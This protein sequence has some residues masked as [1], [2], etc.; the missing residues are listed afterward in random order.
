MIA[1]FLRD[2]QQFQSQ[3]PFFTYLSEFLETAILKEKVFEYRQFP[4]LMGVINK[5]AESNLQIGVYFATI[6]EDLKKGVHY[7]KDTLREYFNEWAVMSF[8]E[9]TPR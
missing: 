1:L 7:N 8:E 9:H 4:N 6:L 2:T 3:E 5:Y